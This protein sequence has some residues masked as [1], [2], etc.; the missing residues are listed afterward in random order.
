MVCEKVYK[1]R[2]GGAPSKDKKDERLYVMTFDRI[3][4]F[5]AQTRKRLYSI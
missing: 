1:S 5:K 3:Y 2:F 4:M